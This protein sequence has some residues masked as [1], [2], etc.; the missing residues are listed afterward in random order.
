MIMYTKFTI[1][2]VLMNETDG[3]F[4]YGKR[5]VMHIYEQ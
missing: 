2:E 4:D 3:Y 5:K 1:Y